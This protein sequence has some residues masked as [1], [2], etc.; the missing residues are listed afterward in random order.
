MYAL[1]C[2]IQDLADVAHSEVDLSVFPEPPEELLPLG[3]VTNTVI[4]V[5]ADWYSLAIQLNIDYKTRTVR[6]LN[7]YYNAL[8]NYNIVY[9]CHVQVI[10]RDHPLAEAGFYVMLQH[11][12]RRPSPPPS[13][14][15]LI[16]ALKCPVINRAD[17]AADME[18]H[19][20]CCTIV[21]V[22]YTTVQ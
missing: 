9:F 22:Q 15:A 21:C 8:I 17:I 7:C 4:G 10:E 11:W 19:Q 2:S 1:F 6:H 13:W 18:A 16:R 3:K 12:V 5:R 20:V 14:S